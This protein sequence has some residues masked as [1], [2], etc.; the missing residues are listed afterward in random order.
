MARDIAPVM[1]KLL[2]YGGIFLLV[3][4][5]GAV[6]AQRHAG[7]GMASPTTMIVRAD[8]EP[9]PMDVDVPVV[10][11][12]AMQAT[13]SQPPAVSTGSA[14]VATGTM[15][16]ATSTGEGSRLPLVSGMLI[17]QGYSTR[18]DMAWDRTIFDRLIPITGKVMMESL[19]VADQTGVT[20]GRLVRVAS[21]EDSAS[22]YEILRELALTQEGEKISVSE[23]TRGRV[24][25]FVYNDLDKKENLRIVVQASAREAIALDLPAYLQG[26]VDAVLSQL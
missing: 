13:M 22:A 3:F 25:M 8:E 16:G 9:A 18:P 23:T 1:Q 2:A 14:L 11:E 20:V 4:G 21:V 6:Y 24:R 15:L 5:L 7:K 10:V 12:P 26:V 19:L 17:T